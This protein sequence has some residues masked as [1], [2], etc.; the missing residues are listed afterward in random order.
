VYLGSATNKSIRKIV[1]NIQTVHVIT[2]KKP[3]AGEKKSKVGSEMKQKHEPHYRH[4]HFSKAKYATKEKPSLPLPHSPAPALRLPLPAP[5]H[6]TP[7]EIRV[8]PCNQ[9]LTPMS[10]PSFSSPQVL[11][12]VHSLYFNF[13]RFSG[14]NLRWH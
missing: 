7:S 2:G 10:F 13:Q 1:R 5:L 14:R 3:V 9:P 8:K 12:S 11:I 4:W 6:S